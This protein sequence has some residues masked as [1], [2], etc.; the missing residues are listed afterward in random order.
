MRGKIIS[1]TI[2]SILTLNQEDGRLKAGLGFQQ[3]I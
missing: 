2:L 1:M 3:L